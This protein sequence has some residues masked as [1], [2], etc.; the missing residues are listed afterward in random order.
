M[1]AIFSNTRSKTR[2]TSARNRKEIETIEIPDDEL[3]PATSH[4]L[5]ESNFDEDNAEVMVKVY[6]ESK[7]QKHP[8]RQVQIN[9]SS[10]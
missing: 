3:F 10:S 7:L 9:P 4:S 6:W 8:L 5:P 1:A 2:T